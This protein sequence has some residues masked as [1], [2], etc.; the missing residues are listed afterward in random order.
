MAL[1]YRLHRLKLLSDWRYTQTA[2]RL[3][4]MGYRTAEPDSSMVRESSQLLA[5][6]FD[7]LRSQ[8]MTRADIAAE[9]NLPPKTSTGTCSV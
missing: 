3:T 4:Q 2:K 9:L 1:T 8:G 6:V 7:A 5:K